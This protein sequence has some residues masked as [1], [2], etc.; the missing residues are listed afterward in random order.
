MPPVID[1]RLRALA[2]VMLRVGVNLQP[3]QSLLITEPYELQGIHPESEP[4]A[5]AIAAVAA[6]S[7][8]RVI[9]ADPSRLRALAADN[10]HRGYETL[11]SG[12]IL[13]LDRHLADGGAFL[14]LQGSQPQLMAGVPAERLA[15]L[16]HV[17]W[18][19]LGPLIQRLVRG[20]T[21][22]TL[23]PAPSTSWADVAFPELPASNRLSAL[24]QSVFEALRVAPTG[25]PALSPVDPIGQWQSHLAL[26]ARRRTELN[27]ARHR[28]VRFSGP[29]TDL[30]FHLPRSHA[31][32]TAQLVSK[33]GVPFVANL[34]TEEVFTA[35][36][37]N[38]A[39][40]IARITR[41]VVHDGSV[42]EGLELEFHCGRVVGARARTGQDALEHLLATDSGA[43]RIG[44]VALVMDRPRWASVSTPTHVADRDIDD[45]PVPRF[46][47]HVLL[48]ENAAH[49]I[50]LGD[51]YRFCSRAWLP[52]ALNSSQ[53]HLDLPLDAN[54][55]LS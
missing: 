5:A 15:R 28:H 21:Q 42:I 33:T 52:F 50:A 9:T 3:G 2:E 1:S 55:E 31:W 39:T 46:F 29:G 8:V 26:L 38:S 22:W 4:L 13:Q 30:T 18:R 14:F 41:P 51:A 17:K 48:D 35:P 32:C 12:H 49:H 25:H 19:Y 34:P 11:V 6:G 45:H 24:W 44:E 36:H 20:A 37:K 47:H 27:S 40:G 43:C 53:V 16:N 23:A 10:D 54:I 7:N